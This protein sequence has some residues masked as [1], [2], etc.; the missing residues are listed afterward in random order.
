MKIRCA[1][2]DFD[3]TIAHGDSIHK[4]LGYTFI[5]HPASLIYYVPVFIYG[6]GYLL[7]LVSKETCKSVLLFPLEVLNEGELYDFYAEKVVPSYYPHM[8]AEMKKRQEEGCQ[9]FL[10]TASVE[11]YMRFNKLPVDVLMGTLTKKKGSSYTSEVI[12]KNCKDEHK[13][14]RIDAYMKDKGW[15][16]D[17]DHSY[18]YSDSKSDIPMLKLVKNRYKVDTHDGSLSEFLF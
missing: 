16:I 11:A 5:H 18:A 15:E 8:V 9:V 10:V 13:V 1:F 12:G 3:K 14:E 17:Y 2:F 7:H 4:L 6:V